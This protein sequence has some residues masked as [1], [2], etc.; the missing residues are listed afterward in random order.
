[1][2]KTIL[3]FVAFLM[4]SLTGAQ[5]NHGF[6]YKALVTDN[7]NPVANAI[8]SV[9]VNIRQGSTTR[10]AETHNNVHTDANGIFS[11]IIG[12]GTRTGGVSQFKDVPWGSGNLKL[13]ILVDT[14]TGYVTLVNNEIFKY[15]PYAKTAEKITGEQDKLGVGDY[16]T[17]SELVR[18]KYNT[19]I[20]GQD[21][22]DLEI[23]TAPSSGTAQFIECN[24]SNSTMF[25]VDHN[26]DIYTKGELHH[27]DTGDAN[28]MPIA[29]GFISNDGTIKTGSGNFTVDKTAAGVYK[30]TLNTYTDMNQSNTVIIATAGYNSSQVYVRAYVLPTGNND[31]V[32][33]K[34]ENSSGTQ[35]DKA[36]NFVIYK[37]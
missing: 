36:F 26:G 10:W 8:I 34:T 20:S 12:E 27:N 29:Y 5:T 17:N 33:V 25:K 9:K 23:G 21:V 14:G 19:P 32:F 30:I 13:T 22:L 3:L 28:M 18:F 1:M 37:K 7:G 2:K 16:P 6:N 24:L 15:V 11:I 35:V 31:H 4:A